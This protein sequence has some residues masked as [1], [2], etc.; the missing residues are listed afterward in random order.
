M[1]D[2]YLIVKYLK[3]KKYKNLNSLQNIINLTKLF[4]S[5]FQKKLNLKLLKI[6]L[7]SV[8]N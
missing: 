5:V 3:T 8:K 4:L 2:L 7:G 1:Q 6:S